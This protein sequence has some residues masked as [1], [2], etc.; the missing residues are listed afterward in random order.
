MEAAT[1]P[2]QTQHPEAAGVNANGH[3]FVRRGAAFNW[4]HPLE[5]REGDLDCTFMNDAEFE[6]AVR[7]V[8]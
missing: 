3:H 8:A 7:E 1:S 4:R 5:M 6:Q 2:S